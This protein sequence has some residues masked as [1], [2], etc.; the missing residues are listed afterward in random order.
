MKV[1]AGDGRFN[2]VAYL[3]ADENGNS[4]KV[5]KYVGLDRVNLTESNE[6]GYCSL[7]KATKSVLD[8]LELENKTTTKIK[9]LCGYSKIWIW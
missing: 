7:V 5:S 2:Y 8:K 6:Y 1:D 3:L 4:I 9:N